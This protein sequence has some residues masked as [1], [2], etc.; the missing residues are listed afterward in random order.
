MTCFCFEEVRQ[1]TCSIS[2]HY[3]ILA[4][5]KHESCDV[6]IAQFVSAFISFNHILLNMVF[7]QLQ[8]ACST[9]LL[10]FITS[11]SAQ[12]TATSS[13]YGI[14]SAAGKPQTTQSIIY[15]IQGSGIA[16]AS[17]TLPTGSSSSAA[18]T[19]STSGIVLS[20]TG[21]SLTSDKDH[22]LST[23][24]ILGIVFAVI[25]AIVG[26]IVFT[27]VVHRRRR[28]ALSGA[29][30]KGIMDV[31]FAS[32]RVLPQNVTRVEPNVEKTPNV[33]YFDVAKPLPAVVRTSIPAQKASKPL[34]EDRL[35][36]SSTIIADAAEIAQINRQVST[37]QR[38]PK[39]SREG[40]RHRNAALQILITN[41]HNRT[42]VL[43]YSP[44]ASH[45]TISV[46]LE[47]GLPPRVQC[48]DGDG[49]T[50]AKR[51]SKL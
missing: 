49:D 5:L 37:H 11:I 7:K 46:D 19:A 16:V 2:D 40:Q 8:L 43:P 21:G 12:A 20:G 17:I 28:K 9:F 3:I 18:N 36:R 30:R 45:R 47:P 13:E 23:P 44:L 32:P 4:F 6:P 24:A 22:G 10:S 48:P 38:K 39:E 51:P 15:S 29:K 35:S 34:E 42:S 31:E 25:L 27:I 33:G 41:E 50:S 1:W 26:I 14:V